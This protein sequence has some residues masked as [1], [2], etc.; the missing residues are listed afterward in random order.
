MRNCI[1]I[2]AIEQDAGHRGVSKM[3]GS[4]KLKDSE[5]VVSAL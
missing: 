1:V 5:T 3:T 2:V 4:I